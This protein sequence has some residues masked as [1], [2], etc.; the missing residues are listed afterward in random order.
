MNSRVADGKQ[1]VFRATDHG[2][3]MK[4]WTLT[5]SWLEVTAQRDKFDSTYDHWHS[6]KKRGIDYAEGYGDKQGA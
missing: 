5:G 1:Y 2:Q 6:R 3:E 4:E